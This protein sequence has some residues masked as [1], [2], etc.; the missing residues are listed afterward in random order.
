[1][2]YYINIF[3]EIAIGVIILYGAYDGSDLFSQK[4]MS[5]TR[6]KI[7]CIFSG[8]LWILISGLRSLSIGADTESYYISYNSIKTVHISEL[9]NEVYRKYILH[10][11]IK[12]PGYNLFVKLTQ[13]ITKDYQVFLIIIA[14][15]FMVPFIIWIIRESK[16]PIT[17]FVLYSSLF[18]AFFSITGIRQTIATAM[19][20]LIGDKLIKDKKLIAFIIIGL[21]ASTIHQSALIFIPFYFLSR[22]PITKKS[23]CGWTFAIALAFI[24]RNQLKAVF[25]DLSGYTEYAEAYEGA[26]TATFTLMLLALFI[27][28]ISSYKR[29]HD[30]YT[31]NRFYIA[32]YLALFFV[33]LTWINPSAMR[34]VQYFSIYLV[35]LIPEMIESTFT[36][37]SKRIVT[38]IAVGLLV[39]LLIR[40][41]PSYSFFWQ[42]SIL[43]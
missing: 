40:S 29:D 25:I 37:N 12:D 8:F 38:I 19:V 10:Q 35:L 26:G 20:V 42:D 33:P 5:L 41:H 28:S 43:R 27:L 36:D 24:F 18:Y 11:D 3:F 13:F 23:I 1:M 4:P 30:L 14:I 21:L 16:N 31:N 32:L 34:I 2:I 9:I 22:I 17:S 39:I 15:I 7:Y 6:K